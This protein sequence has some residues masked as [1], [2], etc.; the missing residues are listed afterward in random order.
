MSLPVWNGLQMWLVVFCSM[1]HTFQGLWCV[2]ARRPAGKALV[3][4]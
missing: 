2:V 3:N 1:L 4:G